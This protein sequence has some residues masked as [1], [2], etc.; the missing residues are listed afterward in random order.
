M[1]CSVNATLRVMLQLYVCSLKCSTG[2]LHRAKNLSHPAH[3]RHT[4][5]GPAP[6]A[7]TPCMRSKIAVVCNDNPRPPPLIRLESLTPRLPPNP[8][9]TCSR[10]GPLRRPQ[11]PACHPGFLPY[12]R[13]TASSPLKGALRCFVVGDARAFCGGF[14]VFCSW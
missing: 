3:P 9:K 1:P 13:C 7:A 8:P 4:C 14:E 5:A 10:Q 12:Q 2:S 11:L 6:A